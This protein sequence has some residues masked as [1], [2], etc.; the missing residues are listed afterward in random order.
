MTREEA[1]HILIRMQEPEAY[2]PQ[3]TADAYGALQMAIE[4]L[5]N[6]NDLPISP[7]LK[8]PKQGKNG[9]GQIGNTEK[10]DD[11]T[12]DDCI[13]RQAAIDAVIK[14]DYEFTG[15]LSEPRARMFEQTINALPSAQPLIRTEMSSADDI[16]SR[17]AAIDALD[18]IGSLDTEA[19]RKYARSALE[20]LPSAQPDL[21]EYSDK[22]WRA[23]YE[24]G[25]KEAQP[26]IIRCKDCKHVYICGRH[27]ILG[28]KPDDYCS[29]AERRTDER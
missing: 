19:D 18:S 16:I 1:I 24:R 26:E 25:K 23:A 28:T 27:V 17:Q 21:S 6:K 7:L 5:R 20:A 29:W 2:E 10:L 11:R 8:E 22:L 15:I 9:S 12:T 3:I 14:A 13:S 4:A